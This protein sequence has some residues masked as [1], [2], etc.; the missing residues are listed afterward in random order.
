MNAQRDGISSIEDGNQV[1]VDATVSS[2]TTITIQIIDIPSLVARLALSVIFSVT[3]R[4]VMSSPRQSTRATPGVGSCAGAGSP[5]LCRRDSPHRPRAIG[6]SAVFGVVCVG[7]GARCVQRSQPGGQ[8]IP[9]GRRL[10]EVAASLVLS[11][12]RS[13]E[14]GSTIVA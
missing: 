14:S 1:M 11:A 9:L 12:R 8:G 6:L 4:Y 3:C 13:A 10:A 7:S 2:D 5:L